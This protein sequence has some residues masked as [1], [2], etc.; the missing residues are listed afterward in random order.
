M[1][2]ALR[3]KNLVVQPSTEWRVIDAEP[4]TVLGLYTGY[5]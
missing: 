3:V 1:N 2:L 5:V 4:H